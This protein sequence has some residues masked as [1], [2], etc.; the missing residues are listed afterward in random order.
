MAA[1]LKHVSYTL[2]TDLDLEHE[3]KSIAVRALMYAGATPEELGDM[4]SGLT[5]IDGKITRILA[6]YVANPKADG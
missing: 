1:V 6:V 2:G 4:H 3:R 5:V